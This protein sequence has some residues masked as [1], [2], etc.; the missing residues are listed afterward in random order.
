MTV[1]KKYQN[2]GNKFIAYQN[3][4][5]GNNDEWRDIWEDAIIKIIDSLPHGSGINF[6]TTFDFINSKPDKLIIQSA[7]QYMN[8]GGFNDGVID[9]KIIL[10]PSWNDLNIEIKGKFLKKHFGIKDY[11]DELFYNSLIEDQELEFDKEK[12]EFLIK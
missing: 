9:L 10:T 7:Y 3:C 2:L 8:E 4:I 6:D 1:H 12:R 5:K 11:L